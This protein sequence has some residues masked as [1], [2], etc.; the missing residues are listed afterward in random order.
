MTRTGAECSFVFVVVESEPPH[1][2][3]CYELDDDA[4]DLGDEQ[5]E[6]TL[7][8]MAKCLKS[9]DWTEPFEREI[10]KLSLPRW[11]QYENEWTLE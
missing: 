5:N 9:G 2:V 1:R 8:Q 7:A 10:T 6:L 4:M 11:T 3:A